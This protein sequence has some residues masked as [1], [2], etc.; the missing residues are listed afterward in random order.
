M[1]IKPTY[2]GVYIQEERSGVQTI[3]GVDTS[4]AAFFGMSP[5]GP[6]G[7]PT[8]IFSY[9][10]FESKFGTETNRG[11]LPLQ[12]KLF[13]L[14]GGGTAWITRLAHGAINA[15][16]VLAN[17]TGAEVLTL[18]A[19][20][21]GSS[22]NSIQVE[23]DYDTPSPERT[24][25]LTIYRRTLDSKGNQVLS[26][27]ETLSNLS[28][29]PASPAFVQH[30]I[31]NRS[32]LVRA[33]VSSAVTGVH[34]DNPAPASMNGSISGWIF[35]AADLEDNI[36][37]SFG[38]QMPASDDA[39]AFGWLNISV[40][41]QPAVPVQLR[42]SA[43][44]PGFQAA[45]QAAIGSALS[46]A[47]H[48]GSVTVNAQIVNGLGFLVFSSPDGPVTI[49]SAATADLAAPMRLGVQNG[50]VETDSFS[51]LRPAQTG[52]SARPHGAG[53]GPDLYAPNFTNIS[54]I[55]SEA[56][57][58]ISAWSFVVG[59]TTYARPEAEPGPLTG[60][61]GD[62]MENTAITL[63][64]G[65]VGSFAALRAN[66]QVLAGDLQ[67]RTNRAWDCRVHGLRLTLTPRL[68][69]PTL[70]LG[71]TLTMTH[72]TFLGVLFPHANA[73]GDADNLSAYPLGAGALGHYSTAGVAGN[74]GD[75][76]QPGDYDD[77]YLQLAR[78][79]DIFN[80]LLLPR[81]RSDSALQSD[82]ER[83]LLWGPASA[84]CRDNRAFLIMDPPSDEGE[85]SDV[86]AVTGSNGVE[87]LRMGVVGDHAAL[88]WPRVRVS[89]DAGEL[90]T[91]DPCGAIAGLYA[92]TD[93]KRGVWKAPAGISATLT[94]VRGLEHRITD[95]ENGVTNLAAVN[96]NRQ[97]TQGIVSW[98]SRTLAGFENSGEDDW[99]YVP[100]RRTALFIEESLYRGLKFAVFEP[101]DERLWAQIRLAAGA[102]MNNLFRQ[103][104][105]KGSKSSEAYLVNCDATTT[106]QNDI[107]L[108]IVNVRVGFAA[109]KPAEFVI[110]TIRQMAGQIDV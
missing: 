38:D 91:V 66:L 37:S 14:N 4:I 43:D 92:R 52:F 26:D 61:S 36:L 44:W 96:T 9:S 77:A 58:Q 42:P 3:A 82:A 69:L 93:N 40:N 5:R 78:E 102:F 85:W 73:A 55:M 64:T 29:D 50:G 84:F 54:S 30:A 34:S 99:R 95:P 20:D 86:N 47:G 67:S 74:D 107:N 106:T 33:Q 76:P 79:A 13:Y 105:F 72:A 17:E 22:G 81:A 88:Y 103:G 18:S 8:R 41:Y 15:T 2:P 62:L 59:S 65:V 7:V 28:M 100:V 101:N 12:V 49:R 56:A 25:N 57:S 71:A 1:P 48:S 60:A 39:G 31:E 87:T 80:I 51:Q 6:I 32:A 53:A 90:H 10:E 98:G 23:V 68:K 19:L 104:A 21:A 24:F 46:N 97:F 94:G 11:E 109:L 63:P 110:V 75:L 108:G 45:A 27:S 89:D 83:A 35:D 16:A 70:G